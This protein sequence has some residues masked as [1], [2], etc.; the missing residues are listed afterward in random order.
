MDEV[1]ADAGEFGVGGPG[2]GGAVG[3]QFEE[4]V[5][6]VVDDEVGGVLSA[7]VG[8]LMIWCTPLTR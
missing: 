6:D 3:G 8:D 1:D 5:G 2:A 7:V 4:L